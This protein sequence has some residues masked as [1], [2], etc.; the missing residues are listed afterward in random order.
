MNASDIYS[1]SFCFVKFVFCPSLLGNILLSWEQQKT[2]NKAD[3]SLIKWRG[4]KFSNKG[5][6]VNVSTEN[7][8]NL[9]SESGFVLKNW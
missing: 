9:A 2:R 1:W 3:R 7:C 6:E 4:S 8:V 5:M